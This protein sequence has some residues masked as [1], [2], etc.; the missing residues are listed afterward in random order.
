MKEYNLLSP[1]KVYL[2]LNLAG[3]G[4]R[5]V[6]LFIDSIF[7]GLL[8]VFVIF[9]FIYSDAGINSL[10]PGALPEWWIIVILL[11]FGFVIFY[12]YFVFFETIWNG[13]TPGKRL[14]KLRV[15]QENGSSVTFIK[16]LIR[17]I[18]RII[19]SLPTAYAIGII[20][21][22]ISKKN[23]RLGDL[24]AGTVIIREDVE[25]APAAID[26][27][28]SEAPWSGVA[29]LHLHEIRE[30]EFATLKKYLLRRESLPED[31]TQ[32]FEQKLALF[33][34]RKLGLTP[35]EIGSPSEFLKQVAAMYVHLLKST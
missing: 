6:A 3:V 14:L 12:G 20:S 22:L 10:V 8:M 7:Q 21:I 18:L 26:F 30:E 19:D 9:G 17:N 31:E 29:R 33:F 32:D 34:S 2:N 1:E 4:S 28:V 24:A 23:Q 25:A 16:V 27:A 5:F 11:L 35:E 15:V 13:Q